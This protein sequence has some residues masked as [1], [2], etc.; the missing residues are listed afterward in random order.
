MKDGSLGDVEWN[1]SQERRLRGLNSD[2]YPNRDNHIAIF[3]CQLKN[4]PI[5]ILQDHTHREFLMSSRLNF[6]GWRLVDLD[7]YMQGNVPFTQIGFKD[8]QERLKHFKK[9][10]IK[11]RDRREPLTGPV[12]EKLENQINEGLRWLDT[13]EPNSNAQ[14]GLEN[15]SKTIDA[16]A[17]EK[18][19]KKE[20]TGKKAK[21]EESAPEKKIEKEATN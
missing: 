4:P 2:E 7:N 17:I 21:A 13:F 1:S 10:D 16:A 3:E 18:P 19:A 6:S 20:K 5:M 8:P 12:R 15:A 9:L 14:I 11:E